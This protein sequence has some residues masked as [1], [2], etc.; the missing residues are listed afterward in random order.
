MCNEFNS[1]SIR[2][3]KGLP[4]IDDTRF[5][6]SD[7]NLRRMKYINFCGGEPF[8]SNHTCDLLQRLS[9]LPES[10]LEKIH[11]NFDTNLSF[12]GKTESKAFEYFQKFPNLKIQ[13]SLD[14]CGQ[15]GEYVRVGLNFS[16]FMRYLEKLKKLNV[17]TVIQHTVTSI[18]L[19]ELHNVIDVSNRFDFFF[20]GR[21]VYHHDKAFFLSPDV[22]SKEYH[23]QC[24]VNAELKSKNTSIKPVVLELTKYLRESY[25]PVKMN[26]HTLV[27]SEKL[28]GGEGFFESKMTGYLNE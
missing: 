19:Q 18:G 23:E 2:S 8:M 28:F 11:L 26:R 16:T 17:N 6:I 9:L 22:V 5:E 21:R 25:S 24:L 10:V 13:A 7:E 12:P 3:A 14:G 27:E 4:S 15:I 1:S 20:I